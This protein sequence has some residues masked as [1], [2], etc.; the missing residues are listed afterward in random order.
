[1]DC[2]TFKHNL[3]NNIIIK[4]KQIVGCD[5]KLNSDTAQEIAVW[6]TVSVAIAVDGRPG[7]KNAFRKLALV[8]AAYFHCKLEPSGNGVGLAFRYFNKLDFFSFL[9][10]DM[11]ITDKNKKM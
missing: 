10:H 3:E 7:H 2:F 4:S 6:C 5:I 1:M 9:F 8:I 11:I